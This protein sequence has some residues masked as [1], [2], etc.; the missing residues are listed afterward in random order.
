MAVG[1]E[2]GGGVEYLSI[3]STSDIPWKL[4]SVNG[5]FLMFL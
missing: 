2:G 3:R 1:G 5:Y 4:M